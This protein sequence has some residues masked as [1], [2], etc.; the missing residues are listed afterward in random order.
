MSVVVCVAYFNLATN[1]HFNILLY[2]IVVYFVTFP[3]AEYSSMG[4]D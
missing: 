3:L 1:I 4:A 2:K